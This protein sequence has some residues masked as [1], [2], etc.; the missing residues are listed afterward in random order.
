MRT[1][2]ELESAANDAIY[3]HMTDRNA[4]DAA[5]ALSLASARYYANSE[6]A[7]GLTMGMHAMDAERADRIERLADVGR[8]A[9]VNAAHGER[10]RAA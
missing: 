8:A 2:F 6:Y 4:V 5:M 10:V 3:N 9:M 7:S 1:R